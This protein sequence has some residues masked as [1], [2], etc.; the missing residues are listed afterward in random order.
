MVKRKL[1]GRTR[2]R[3]LTGVP[4]RLP[5]YSRRKEMS[6]RWES[7]FRDLEAQL[8]QAQRVELE[9]EVADRTR[10]E[11]GQLHLVH[12]LRPA[13]G[14][15]VT[16]STL[17]AGTLRGRL[18]EVGAEWVVLDEGPGRQALIP[19][20]AVSAVGGL[21]RLSASPGKEGQVWLRLGLS[22]ALRAVARDRQP[23]QCLL[24]DAT[25][26][27][28]TVDAVGGDFFELAE[29]AVGELRRRGDVTGVRTV[30]FGGLAAL[31]GY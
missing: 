29:H 6:L 24:Q 19:L 25:T 3:Q 10:S 28:G 7:L 21:G 4:L 13:V 12:R 16:I 2:D 23:V 31:R 9:A 14:A 22:A 15:A 5:A 20:S 30:P 27:N 18:A 1:C 17:G 11:R 26:L 8:A